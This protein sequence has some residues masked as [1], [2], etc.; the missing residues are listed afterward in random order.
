MG[1]NVASESFLRAYL[2]YSGD[3]RIFITIDNQDYLTTFRSRYENEIGGRSVYGISPANYNYHSK[4]GNVFFPSPLIGPIA[5]KRHLFRS[6]SWSIT[7][8][9]H[10]TSSRRITDG[11]KELITA[12][13]YSWD[14]VVCTSSAVKAH[15]VNILEGRKEY[16]KKRF[17]KIKYTMAN[18]PVIPLGIF[19][20]DFEISERQ[21]YEARDYLGVTEQEVVVLYVGRL[22]FHAKSNPLA[23]YQALE[24]ASRLVSKNIVLVEVGWYANVAIENAYIDARRKTLTNVRSIYLDGTSIEQRRLGWSA[25]DIFCSLSDNIQ[26][27]FGIT[28]VEAMAAGL[29][30][31]ASDWNGY[32]DTIRHGKEGFLVETTMPRAGTGCELSTRYQLDVDTYDRYCGYTSS[33]IEVNIDLAAHYFAELVQNEELRLKMANAAKARADRTY[34]WRSIIPQYKELWACN[35]ELRASYDNIDQQLPRSCLS[36]P[37]NDFGHYPTSRISVNTEIKLN[38]E[39]AELALARYHFLMTLAMVNFSKV[40]HP[41]REEVEKICSLLETTPR[42]I[43]EILATIPQARQVHVE[44]GISALLKLGII[45]RLP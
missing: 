6:Q 5:E 39:N 24:Q 28:P 20:D 13:V 29:P 26:E 23:M 34:N 3:E 15:L 41:E 9:T 42:S 32:K 40:I 27:T 30:V 37:F 33:L 17:G 22:S 16:L 35:A 12:P 8:V 10:T 19:T 31:I 38:L 4:V 18:M 1:R 43:N 2:S 14:S 25:S 21:R 11:V 7:G 36:D 44:R 45:S